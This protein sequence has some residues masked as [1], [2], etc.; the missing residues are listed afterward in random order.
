MSYHYH[1]NRTLLPYSH[2]N[3]KGQTDAEIRLWAYLR[4]RRLQGYKFRRQYPVLNYILDFY[5]VDR[6]LA[7]ELD[8]GQHLE[9]RFYDGKRAEDL[10]KLGIRVIRFWDDDVLGHTDDV[11]EQIWIMLES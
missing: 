8:G 4:N 9:R 10:Q 3:R 1:N 11:L 7:V 6:K 5:C 2:A